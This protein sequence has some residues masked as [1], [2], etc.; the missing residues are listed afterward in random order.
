MD[1]LTFVG[2][3]GGSLRTKNFNSP[4][5]TVF[6][7]TMQN[8]RMHFQSGK[9]EIPAE[10]V[11]Q[12]PW[13]A[14]YLFMIAARAK[15]GILET[16]RYN[17][18]SALM[19]SCANP[20]VPIYSIDLAPQNDALLRDLFEKLQVGGNVRLIEGDTQ[21]SKYPEI[22]AFDVLF[23]DGDHS[24]EGCTAD[25]E[26]WYDDLVPGGHVLLHDSYHGSPVMDS[27]VDFIARRR[28][29]VHQSPYRLRN[30][31]LH[32]IGSITHFQKPFDAS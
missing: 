20:D 11:R 23:I 29:I 8:R 5:D 16:G 32:P 22:G 4:V 18:G 26:N 9:S 3:F 25:L 13:E 6:K 19:M 28:P 21:R 30:H 17:G 1:F 27:C 7:K 12:D 24:Y 10:F 31:S 2:R 14:E 15:L